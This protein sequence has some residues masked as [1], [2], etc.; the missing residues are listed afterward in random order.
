MRKVLLLGLLLVTLTSAYSLLEA[1]PTNVSGE[2]PSSL[3]ISVQ[4]PPTPKDVGALKITPQSLLAELNSRRK[5]VGVGPLR[6]DERLNKSAQAKCDDMLQGK[7]YDHSAPVTG[8]RGYELARQ[9]LGNIPGKF[10]ENLNSPLE[11]TVT[12]KEVFDSWFTS[13]KHKD[14]ALSPGYTLTGFG[15]CTASANVP[16]AGYRTAV[17]HFYGPVATQ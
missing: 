5:I 8:V 12:A 17:Q 14:A 16:S 13:E 9:E 3:V 1:S 7:Y 2:T 10:G 11:S 4:T 6:L 15:Y